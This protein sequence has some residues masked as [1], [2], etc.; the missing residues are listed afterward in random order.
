MFNLAMRHG[1]PRI[2]GLLPPAYWMDYSRTPNSEIAVAAVHKKIGSAPLVGAPA[3]QLLLI[4]PADF[5]V[6][7]AQIQAGK[8]LSAFNS[9]GIQGGW[10]EPERLKNCGSYLEGL[11][12]TIDGLALERRVGQEH[13]HVDVVMREAAMFR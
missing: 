4:A 11:H 9:H 10:I 13:D 1:Y 5:L 3:D 7:V 12:G 6:I 8:N 2:Y